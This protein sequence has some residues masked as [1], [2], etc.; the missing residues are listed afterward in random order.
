MHTLVQKI[1]NRIKSDPIYL[2]IFFYALFLFVFS[3]FRS[4]NGDET[5]YLKETVLIAEL[6][7]QGIWIGD[8]GV[9][10]HGFLFKLP[11]AILFIILGQPSV[12]VATSFTIIISIVSLILFYKILKNFLL[13]GFYAFWAVV[14]LSVT[15]YFIN[16]SLSFN[17]DIPA[18]FTVL[19]FM[20]SFFYGKRP[21][22]TGF[23][24]LLMLDAKEHVFFTIAPVYGIYLLLELFRSKKDKIWRNVKSF[25]ITVFRGY[26]LSILWIVLM[27]TTSIIP[28]NM[29]V[30][31]IMGITNVGMNWNKSQF[32]FSTASQNLMERNVKEMPELKNLVL[33]IIEGNKNLKVVDG[34]DS[35]E[36]RFEEIFCAK[37]K[38]L[39][40]IFEKAD[41]LLG[42]IGKILYPRTFSFISIP[43]IIVLPSVVYSISLFIKWWKKKDKRYILPMI[44]VFNIL[45][46]IA[47][48]SHGR[49]LLCVSPIFM[50]FFTLFIKDGLSSEKYFLKTLIATNFFVVFGLFF[51]STFLTQKIIL[52]SSLLLLLWL[53]YLF[54]NKQ[55]KI[56]FT[57][58]NFFLIA[59]SGGM[60]LTS[61]AFSSEIGQLSNYDKY[62]YNKET[63][64]IVKQVNK[65]DVIWI[66]D[67]GVGELVNV[68]RRNVFNEPSWNW[69]LPDWIPKTKLLKTYGENNT[70]TS[71]ILDMN[72]F[73]S[74][75]K[76]FKINK[77]ILLKSLKKGDSFSNSDKLEIFLQQDWLKLE[78]TMYMK[79]KILYIFKVE[80]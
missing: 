76:D 59:L 61:L 36:R 12:F 25:F 26:I 47:R 73:R 20:Y 4:A 15:L 54:R 8:Y 63:S 56:L 64:E 37:N 60:F 21:W 13:K 9:G 80:D 16:T 29:F 2:Y 67:Y 46:V 74:N 27:F 71:E 23:T 78:K 45:I 32:S 1:K 19:L 48:A 17:R 33:P 38:S 72:S 77:V 70:F 52:E 28:V 39:C 68:Y 10:L 42:Y 51:E 44:L 62:G 57:I 30:A 58:K 34:R 41:I 6:L 22:F 7:K 69:T 49:Y 14:L 50:L 66:N 40:L 55:K 53:I 18:L 65:E 11:L 24:L 31:S 3:F 5:Y 75:I 43:K 79:N 35:D